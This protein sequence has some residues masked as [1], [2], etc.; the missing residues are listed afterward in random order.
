MESADD[1]QSEAWQDL[2]AID[3]IGEIVADAVVTFFH[4]PHNRHVLE[5]L[6]KEVSPTP[7][8]AADTSSPVA[9]KT[10]VFTGSL[11]RMTRSEAKARAEGLGAKVSG[12]VSSK[13]DILV[14]GP[15][16]GS[17][18]KKAEELDIQVLTEDEWLELIADQE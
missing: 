18:L 13:T 6:L 7:L 14:A 15:G 16:A 11:E 5:D 4:E 17:K 8:A 12:S 3:G 2:L 10:V 1:R 9:G